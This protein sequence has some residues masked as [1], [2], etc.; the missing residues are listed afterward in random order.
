MTRHN[1]Y[2]KLASA[3]AS[4]QAQPQPPDSIARDLAK[5]NACL[6][7]TNCYLAFPSPISRKPVP[8]VK[9]MAT[10]AAHSHPNRNS[11]LQEA[12]GKL[13]LVLR[14]S[15][16]PQTN[17][18][19]SYG[20]QRFI[21][22]ASKCGIP[23]ADALPADPKIVSLFIASGVGS[24]SESTA[25]GNLSAIAAW[26]RI[27]GFPFETPVQVAI[28]RKGLRALWPGEK[29]KKAARK[30][31]SPGM[32]LALIEEWHDGSPRELCAL[33]IALSAWCGIARLGELL[34]PSLHDVDTKRLPRR[35]HWSPSPTIPNSSS[36]FLPWTKTTMWKGATICLLPQKHP[37]DPSSAISLHLAASPMSCTHLLCQYLNGNTVDTMDKSIFIS[38]ANAV[39]QARG[40]PHISG[41]S[42]RIGGTTTY[43][44]A[45]VNPK[46]VKKMGRWTSDAFLLYWR[47]TEEIFASH[48]SNLSWVD[49]AI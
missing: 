37:Y 23:P 40:W 16:A 9:D 43:L 21:H 47:N 35:L 1:K 25:R 46:V 15:Y 31:V 3:K 5:L 14:N 6:T 39:W 34:P 49:F 4:K 28:I 30:P 20:I 10:I 33:A 24:T 11:F 17:K 22:F 27:N 32:I 44:R 36:I 2:R 42:F 29:Q 41:H 45:G 19:Y 18:N 26:H 48:A 8:N 12:E 38:M 13:D 7:R